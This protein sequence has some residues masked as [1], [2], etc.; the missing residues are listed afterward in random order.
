MSD[1]LTYI[2]SDYL[3]LDAGRRLEMVTAV[4]WTT[5]AR[6]VQMV[7]TCRERR[8]CGV[9]TLN[10][11]LGKLLVPP[12]STKRAR[13]LALHFCCINLLHMLYTMRYSKISL[14]LVLGRAPLQ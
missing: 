1:R 6:A 3:S 8:R 7:L 12:T 2:A 13:S 10:A 9:S 5:R 4:G 11:R 14:T